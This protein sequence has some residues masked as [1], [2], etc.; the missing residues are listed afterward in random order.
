M[1][2]KIKCLDEQCE[3]VILPRTAEETG[4]FCMPCSGKRV[5]PNR[6]KDYMDQSRAY[7]Q[8]SSEG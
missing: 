1:V 6:V 4:G 3:A 7:E 2:D 5:S 8:F